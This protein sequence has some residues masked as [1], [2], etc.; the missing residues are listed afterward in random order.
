MSTRTPAKKAAASPAAEQ[1][2]E[3]KSRERAEAPPL[4]VAYLLDP[5]RQLVD[6][7]PFGSRQ[8]DEVAAMKFALA[9]GYQVL[10]V[11]AGASVRATI[12]SGDPA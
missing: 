3:K 1:P 7:V 11:P 12:E 10:T 6:V 8:V 9:K 4:H 5:D 2:T